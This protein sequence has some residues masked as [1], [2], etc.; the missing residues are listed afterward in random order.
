MGWLCRSVPKAVNQL[1]QDGEAFG[2]I[3]FVV[4]S[5]WGELWLQNSIVTVPP[6]VDS[7]WEGG[8]VLVCNYSNWKRSLS[9]S[10]SLG[11]SLRVS[12]SESLSLYQP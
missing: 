4:I 3:L 10:L 9:Q 12:L 5:V 8:R 7:S 1:D 11:V 6:W 2:A